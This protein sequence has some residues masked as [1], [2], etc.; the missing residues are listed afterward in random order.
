[1]KLATLKTNHGFSL[2]ETMVGLG[3]STV[4]LGVT[5]TCSIA[6]QRSFKATDSFFAAHIQ[7]IRVIDYLGRDVKRGLSVITS[8]D[9]KTVTITVPKY[10]IKAGDPEAVA[11]PALIG[12]P[13]TPTISIGPNGPQVN[14]GSSV[15]TVAYAI[16]GK[17]VSRTEDSV[18]TDVA[19]SADQLV[20]TTTNVQLA[21]TEYSKMWVTFLPI[22]SSNSSVAAQTNAK[23][24]TSMYATAYLRN[25]RRG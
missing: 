12:T 7:Q 24:G 3:L 17:S 16:N 15:S 22:F 21:N 4:L 23:K 20:P 11:N 1:M 19:S 5:I 6:L 8:T 14:Y 18:V 9:L 13:R 25:K 10:I 2:S